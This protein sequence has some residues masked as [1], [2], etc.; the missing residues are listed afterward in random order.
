MERKKGS[1]SHVIITIV[2]ILALVSTAILLGLWTHAISRRNEQDAL[3]QALSATLKSEGEAGLLSM[4]GIPV[5]NIFYGDEG[6]SLFQGDTGTWNYSADEQQN[7]AVYQ[8]C[9]Q[10]V[11]EIVPSE[12]LSD[13]SSGSGIVIS[14]D[15]FI[16]TNGHVLGSANSFFVNFRNGK[17]YKATLVGKDDI[18][19]IAVVKVETDE[20]DDKL[21]PIAFG[22]ASNLVVGQKAIAIGNP[23]GY[24]WSMSVGVVSGLERMVN[25]AS[26]S[27]LPNMIQ[28]DASINPGN[29]GGP[30]LNGHGE[31][32][33]LNTSIY[34]TSGTSQGISFAI[35]SET[36]LSVATQLVKYG[37]VQRGWL[38][39]LSVE[40]NP[41][42]VAYSSLPI[43]SGILVSQ[44]VPS[45]EADKGGLRG[46][47]EKAQYGSSVI[48][49]GGDVIVKIE[50]R[51][52]TDYVDYF[53]ALFDTKAGEKV[54]LTVVRGGKEVVLK[55]IALVEETRENSRWILR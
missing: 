23:F 47:N 20:K 14:S 53:T 26:G 42:I 48:Y 43:S 52:I 50:D 2:C 35:P 19:D 4:A 18:T 9:A 38:D 36:V 46:G 49:L 11:V 25:T 12:Q 40:L 3:R 30:L 45:G 37:K 39:I 41:Q 55:N 32:V 21:I 31:L 44:V 34:S 13:F 5:S 29:S 15:G 1:A 24:G 33:G 51:P 17:S 8:K 10:S 28:T 16:I 22:S 27:V 6:L 54:D 7:I